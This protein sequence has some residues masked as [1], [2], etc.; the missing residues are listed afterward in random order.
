[1]KIQNNTLLAR[2]YSN[3]KVIQNGKPSNSQ[4]KL[5]SH[6]NQSLEDKNKLMLCSGNEHAKGRWVKAEKESMKP[7]MPCCGYNT[8]DGFKPIALNQRFP[9][10][11]SWK[12]KAQYV[13][14][15]S[16]RTDGLAFMGSHGCECP[17]TNADAYTWIPSDCILQPWDPYQ[18]CHL[19]GGRKLL[20]IGDSMMQQA[21]VVLMNAVA[22]AFL[23]RS[24]GCQH[25]VIMAISDSLV[26]TPRVHNR[27]KNW[28]AYVLDHR[29][30]LVVLSAGPHIAAEPVLTDIIARVAAEHASALP[31]TPLVWR[32][33]LGAGC[34][35]PGPLDTPPNATFWA[36]YRAARRAYNYHMLAA[37][38]AV[39]AR[40]F[41]GPNRRY[42]DLGPLALRLDGRVGSAPGSPYPGDCTHFC[43]PG[44]LDD[45]LPRLFLQLLRDELPPTT[46]SQPPPL[47]QPPPNGA[48]AAAAPEPSVAVAARIAPAA[49]I[50]SRRG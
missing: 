2:K 26:P 3:P 19:L 50:A 14:V 48:P 44:P 28:T 24:G 45:L 17:N 18:F 34:A 38:D 32:S 25:Q 7:P 43:H 5:V 20:L 11:C 6:K 22:V 10:H 33:Q 16:G 27:G 39:A 41:P 36:G 47:R 21:A 49:P 9:E 23:G 12:R 30:A 46:P 4:G 1:M 42:W 15:F 13:S 31:E 35:G 8:S 37:F 29:P 40:D